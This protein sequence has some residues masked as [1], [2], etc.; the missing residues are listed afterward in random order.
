MDCKQGNVAE[1]NLLIQL[2]YW[3]GMRWLMRRS[4][5]PHLDSHFA[6][7]LGI[8]LRMQQTRA[9]VP[10]KNGV[11]VAGG[12]NSL[13]LFV[14]MHG[15]FEQNSDGVGRASGFEL[16]LCTAFVKQTRIVELLVRVAELLKGIYVVRI[17]VTAVSSELVCEC[18]AKR[19][20]CQL[21]SGL[22]G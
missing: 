1:W 16:G 7:P 21:M 11:V 2:S 15:L 3:S 5:L 10:A 8:K 17:S 12:P 20:Q 19:P 22:D 9:A 6:V 4:L 18:E 14:G 13:G